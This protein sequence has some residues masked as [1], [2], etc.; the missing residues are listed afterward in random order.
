MGTGE[1]MGGRLDRPRSHG[2]QV[3]TAWYRR[4]AGRAFARQVLAPPA[5]RH[6]RD[7]QTRRAVKGRAGR[8]PCRAHGWELGRDGKRGR[9][10]RPGDPLSPRGTRAPRN[11]VASSVS[12]Y[13]PHRFPRIGSGGWRCSCSYRSG[14]VDSFLHIPCIVRKM[15]T[16]RRGRKLPSQ[17]VCIKT[18]AL[19]I[20]FESFPS[21]K[22]SQEVGEPRNSNPFLE[23]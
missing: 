6:R 10:A 9:R 22:K 17:S 2:E 7:R 11:A 5:H 3:T 21:G 16:W 15:G 14:C 20:P 1:R 4:S 18:K 23:I 19:H 8:Q 13:R 12:Q